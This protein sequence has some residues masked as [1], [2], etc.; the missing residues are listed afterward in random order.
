MAFPHQA[1]HRLSH[2]KSLSL[3]ASESRPGLPPKGSCHFVPAHYCGSKE[4]SRIPVQHLRS[5]LGILFLQLVPTLLH[6]RQFALP[7]LDEII[8]QGFQRLSVCSPPNGGKT[9]C[10]AIMPQGRIITIYV[11][12]ACLK[13]LGEFGVPA[14]NRE[15][16]TLARIV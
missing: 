4:I 7:F 15:S 5:L 13:H 2:D 9:V 1:L 12:P 10:F 8:S 11:L 3:A 16:R 14:E 6:K